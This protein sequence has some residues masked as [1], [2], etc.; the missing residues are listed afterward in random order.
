MI[1]NKG[2]YRISIFNFL[3]ILLIAAGTVVFFVNNIINVHKLLTEN[4]SLKEEITRNEEINNNIQIEIERLSAYDNIR[5]V[6]I[7]KLNLKYFNHKHKKLT[8]P[9]SQIEIL[10]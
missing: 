1:K 10:N 6:A 2:I 8:I 9:R 3:V 4:N 7:G 5:G